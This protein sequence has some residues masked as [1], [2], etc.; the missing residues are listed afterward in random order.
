MRE[1]AASAFAACRSRSVSSMGKGKYP[2][3]D[4]DIILATVAMP[5][6]LQPGVGYTKRS[7]T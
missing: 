5:L 4:V 1:T 2:P 6:L 7:G 3:Q